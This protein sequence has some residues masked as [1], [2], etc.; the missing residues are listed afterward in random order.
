M[1]RARPSRLA[2]LQA[3]TAALVAARTPADAT[4]VVLSTGLAALGA[5]AGGIA[6]LSDDGTALVRLAVGGYSA[7]VVPSPE[8]LSLASQ[9]PICVAVRER[10]A[11]FLADGYT[12]SRRF[13]AFASAHAAEGYHAAAALPLVVHGRVLGSLALSYATPQHFG[14]AQRAY[15]TTLAEL[16]A[17]ALDRTRLYE[18]EWERARAS[19]DL[20]RV[21]A[22]LS[23]TLEPGTLYA[24]LLD[25]FSRIL[26][27]D[28]ASVLLHEGGWAVVAGSRG[29]LTVPVG[30]RAFPVTEMAAPLASGDGGRPA[31]VRDTADLGWISVSPFVGAHS[32]RSVLVVPLLVDGNVVGT[33]NV[34]SFT[35][36]FYTERHLALAVTLGEHLTT[37]LRNAR[38]YT[39]ERERAR[40]AEELARV[41]QEQ[42]EEQAIL[43]GVGTA[44]IWRAGSGGSLRAYPRAG[45]AGAA[46]R[47]RRCDELRGWMGYSRGEP[48]RSQR[49]R[50]HPPVCARRRRTCLAPRLRRS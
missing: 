26:P 19:E 18:A 45:G 24:R 44:L 39:A 41:R 48:G 35:P 21:G 49:A 28:H 6:L 34:D 46:M 5:T 20:A 14:R 30:L 17:L 3:I 43:G 15:A 23:A 42:A 25:H 16:V 13:P 47:L 8:R 12:F 32:I 36:D 40:A 50:G 9:A 29:Q 1:D 31:L 2:A 37:A 27:Y 11:I 10:E 33:F 22:L 38:L 4:Q 7:G